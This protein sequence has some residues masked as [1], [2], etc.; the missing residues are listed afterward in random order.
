M[1]LLLLAVLKFC[2][3]NQLFKYFRKWCSDQQLETLNK[4]VRARE[5]IRALTPSTVFLKTCIS[6]RTLPKV[7]QSPIEKSHNIIQTSR[8]NSNIEGAFMNDEIEKN[9]SWIAVLKSKCHVLWQEVRRFLRFLALLRFC[10]YA[11]IIH[12]QN[13]KQI[14]RK[15]KQAWIYFCS[16]D[17]A[18][19]QSQALKTSSVCQITNFLS[20]KSLFCPIVAT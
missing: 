5:R 18:T 10:H 3:T 19:R 9:R 8:H 7:V 2:S 12:D 20:Q 4:A 16:V 11:T 17:L 1:K 14:N 6:E 13:K 15:T